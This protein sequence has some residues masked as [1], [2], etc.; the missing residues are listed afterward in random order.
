MN[1]YHKR[2]SEEVCAPYKINGCQRFRREDSEHAIDTTYASSHNEEGHYRYLL[3]DSIGPEMTPSNPSRRRYKLLAKVGQGTFG[4]V[5]LCWD[6]Q[7]ACYLAVKV[8]RAIRKYS[9][10]AMVEIDIL[11]RIQNFKPVQNDNGDKS[12][13]KNDVNKDDEWEVIPL[14]IERYD[15][16]VGPSEQYVVL[17]FLAH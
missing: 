5:F 9:D 1:Q 7:K 14:Q 12:E 11:N 6:R 10:S 16:T 13:K 2:P 3:G 17:H 15:Q 4:R 8:V